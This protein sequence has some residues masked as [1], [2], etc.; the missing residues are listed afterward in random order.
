MKNR[1]F[2]NKRFDS[3]AKIKV[4]QDGAKFLAEFSDAQWGTGSFVITMNKH[5]INGTGKM[6]LLTQELVVQ[7]RNMMQQ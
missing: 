6:R 2:D 3:A 5:A 1:V 4:L 7:W